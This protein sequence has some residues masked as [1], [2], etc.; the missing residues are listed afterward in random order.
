LSEPTGMRE[1]LNL[2]IESATHYLSGKVFLKIVSYL[3]RDPDTNLPR[4]FGIGERF[5]PL[6]DHRKQIRQA[7]A[8][9]LEN[10]AMKTYAKR[11]LTET[12]P[13]V[14]ERLLYNWFLNA[15]LFG[16]P[17]Q[18]R[19]SERLGVNVPNL[20]LI[21][22]TSACNLKCKGCWAGEYSRTYSLDYE[23]VDRV[24]T[25]AKEL[26]IHWIVVSGGEPFCWPHLFRLAEKHPDVAFMIYTNGTLIDDEKA[27]RILDCGNMSPAFSLEGGREQTDA[28]R[29]EGVFDK[30]CAA[31][32][33][34]RERGVTFGFSLT[35]TRDNAEECVSD[36]FM[37]FLIEKGCRYGWMFHY[38]PI[39]SDV[40]TD[41]LI[42]PEQRAYLAERVPEIRRTRP[43]LFADFWNDGELTLGCIAGGRRYFH[44]NA[45]GDVEPCAFVHFAVDNIKEKSLVEALRSPIFEAYQRR[46]PFSDNLLRPCPLIDVP[47]ALRDIVAESGARPTHRGAESVLSGRVADVLDKRSAE[48]A[49]T[50][51]P[52][53]AKRCARRAADISS[54]DQAV[55][56]KASAS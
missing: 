30:V 45:N 27:D 55:G 40:N 8:A 6:E 17:K 41:L 9:V 32:D 39:G 3:R 20:I 35:V 31:M 29:G 38:I 22:P 12:H 13:R 43:L 23:T 26:G 48:W 11:L 50:C 24:V 25:E 51:A 28:R 18:R 7:R 21:D 14:Q 34:L 37:D 4:L 52:I 16:I 15:M 49:K 10:P 47:Q 36:E 1:R 19:S 46:Q 33:R 2:N 5:A 44:I 42:T 56:G 54:R 53:W